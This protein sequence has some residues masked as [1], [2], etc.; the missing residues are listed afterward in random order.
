MISILIQDVFSYRQIYKRVNFK[1][2]YLSDNKIFEL[3]RRHLKEED[4]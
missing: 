4:L 3:T 1:M 2:R